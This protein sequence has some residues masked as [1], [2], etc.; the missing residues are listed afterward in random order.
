MERFAFSCIWEI[1]PETANII[2]TKFTKSII[3]SKLAMV[4]DAL[5]LRSS[6]LH[7]VFHLY[8]LLVFIY[9]NQTQKQSTPQKVEQF[10]TV[11]TPFN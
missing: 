9:T 11:Q 1:E 4:I 10:A 7:R 8:L 6:N 5:Q 2:S 3:K